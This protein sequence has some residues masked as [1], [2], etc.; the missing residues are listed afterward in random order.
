M[1]KPIT[2]QL[3]AGS[4]W[5]ARAQF[6]VN[7][8]VSIDDIQISF[9]LIDANGVAYLNGP[10]ESVSE[11]P[12]SAALKKYVAEANISIPD[13][14]DTEKS[15]YLRW[16]LERPDGQD[17]DTQELYI[18]ARFPEFIGAHDTVELY[19]KPFE[20]HATLPVSG[21]DED[22]NVFIFRQNT[23]VFA[24]AADANEESTG[25]LGYN[26]KKVIDTET[27]TG[28]TP[29]LSAY[30]VVWK[31]K[32]NNN[33]YEES[34]RLYVITP[35]IGIAAN[36]L[37]QY[38]NRLAKQKRLPEMKMSTADILY[39]LDMGANAF[40]ASGSRLT[41]FTMTNAQGIIKH[42]WMLYSKI[43]A[44]NTLYLEEGFKAFDFQGQAIQ[45]SVDQTQYLQSQADALQ[46]QADAQIDTL[47]KALA[48]RDALGGDGSSI[49][50]RLK[51]AGGL[52][53]GVASNIGAGRPH[54]YNRGGR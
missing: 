26:Y 44:L 53:I 8:D 12:M 16:V 50:G 14:L 15:Y 34:A 25:N 48:V 46:G 13:N 1:A 20:L 11:V 45:L 28:I 19:S 21:R 18:V 9:E 29:Q 32:E 27:A 51:L 42:W 24:A 10:A 49:T 54:F 38:L 22:V 23:E 2:T 31:Y 39:F 47:K 43:Q 3:A 35:S 41:D 33:N 30:F 40:N 4:S 37:H 5:D 17:T 6:L 52:T 7:P 36:E